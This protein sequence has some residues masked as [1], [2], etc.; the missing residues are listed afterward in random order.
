M[1][2]RGLL[3][4]VLRYGWVELRVKTQSSP[5]LQIVGVGSLVMVAML[6]FELKLSTK[7]QLM[8]LSS[9]Y[10]AYLVSKNL[11]APTFHRL[12]FCFD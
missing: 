3:R 11:N 7:K 10:D 6:L 12:T 8:V 1:G 2:G 4:P 9:N 5:K